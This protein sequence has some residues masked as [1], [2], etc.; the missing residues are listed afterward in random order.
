MKPDYIAQSEALLQEIAAGLKE[1]ERLRR[2]TLLA[3]LTAEGVR[4]PNADSLDNSEL[5]KL[6]D[7]HFDRAA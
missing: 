1:S 4:V 3:L 7:Q 6:L 5:R 2:E